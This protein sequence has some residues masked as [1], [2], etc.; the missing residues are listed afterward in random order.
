M[1]HNSDLLPTL[2]RTNASTRSFFARIGQCARLVLIFPTLPEI[3][4]ISSGV[5]L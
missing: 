3:G 2:E 4:S 1:R 5:L